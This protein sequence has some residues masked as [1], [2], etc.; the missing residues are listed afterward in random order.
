MSFTEHDAN[1]GLPVPRGSRFRIFRQIE[2]K[3]MWPILRH[4][5]TVNRAVLS[6]IGD[7]RTQLASVQHFI[8][9]HTFSLEHHTQVLVRFEET[10][11]KLENLCSSNMLNFDQHQ[12]VLDQ[13][14]QILSDNSQMHSEFMSTFDDHFGVLVRF[15]STLSN[16]EDLLDELKNAITRAENV[17]LHRFQEETAVVRRDLTEVMAELDRASSELYEQMNQQINDQDRERVIVHRS[18]AE[19]HMRL[20]QLDLFFAD[21]RRSVMS[22]SQVPALPSAPKVP[23]P[24]DGIYGA[25]ENAFRGS[26]VL[27]KDRLTV[28]L[29]D[30]LAEAANGGDVLDLGTGRAEW[31]EL[32]LSLGIEATGVDTNS[33]NKEV[34]EAAGVK[35]VVADMIEFLRSSNPSSAAVI[36]A[37]HVVEHLPLDILIEFLDLANRV[38][39]PGGLLILETPNPENLIVG[40]STFYLDPTHRQPIPPSLLEFLTSVRGFIDVSVVRHQRESSAALSMPAHI[41]SDLARILAPLFEEINAKFFGPQDYAI[42]ARRI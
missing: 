28:Y 31:L 40:A 8:E 12:K 21:Y 19:Q 36:T 32:L 35:V 20:A 16:H 33:S 18:F 39:R 23:N 25:F 13:L 27:V 3:L 11:S 5:T 30:V 1:L 9:Q 2:A 17:G 15:E 26:P 34:W 22:R 38:L 7:I 4:Q 10:L 24:F 41:G 42:K 6:D 29:S 37:F 14:Q